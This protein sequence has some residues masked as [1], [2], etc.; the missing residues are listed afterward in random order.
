MDLIRV[1]VCMCIYAC[2][3][4]LVL[5]RLRDEAQAGT[6]GHGNVPG[7]FIVVFV[8]LG[9]H[10]REEGHEVR[11]G[12]LDVEEALPRGLVGVARALVFLFFVLCVCVSVCV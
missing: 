8:L 10:L 7:V 2:L 3:V 4:Y 6:A 1:C 12:V 11:E 5:H 9:Q